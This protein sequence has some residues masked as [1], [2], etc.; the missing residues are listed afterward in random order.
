M[1]IVTKATELVYQMDNQQLNQLVEAVKLK[2]THLARQAVR[3]FTVGDNVR[4]KGR[5]GNIVKGTPS[6]SY[7]ARRSS[8]MNEE[9]K[10]KERLEGL[11]RILPTNPELT[12]QLIR[13]MIDEIDLKV[14][15]FEEE[16]AS[17]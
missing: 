17:A 4:F 5:S 15:Q 16:F 11:R 10:L 9:L 14:E 2:R 12:D 13:C 3:S 1:N 7:D 6:S 8:G